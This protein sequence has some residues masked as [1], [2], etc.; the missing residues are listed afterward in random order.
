MDV[1]RIRKRTGGE[2]PV[3]GVI[4]RLLVVP[5]KKNQE[6]RGGDRKLLGDGRETP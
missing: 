3:T 1:K 5:Q 4:P 6:G 2:P